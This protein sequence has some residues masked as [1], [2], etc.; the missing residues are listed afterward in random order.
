ME[1]QRC[2]NCKCW[3]SPADF[4]GA[5]GSTVKRCTK[6][7]EKDIRQKQRPEVREKRNELQR[8]KRYD[9]AWRQRKREADKEAYLKH[10]AAV[11]R[12]W[13]QANKSH[14]K[15]WRT[16]NVRQ[17]LGGIMSQAKTKGYAWALEL[18]A[19][20]AMMK[21]PCFYCGIASED[22]LNGIDRMDSSVG[23]LP[24]NC[25]P[26]CGTCN[27]MKKSLD[28]LTFV[29]RCCQISAHHG[30]PGK[31]CTCW[32]SQRGASYVAYRHRAQKKNM[33][34]DLTKQQ[35]DTLC[36]Q[37][38]S[39]CGRSTTGDHRNG[40]DR[41][42]DTLGYTSSNCVPCCGQCN[43]SKREMHGDAYVSK[44]KAIA[45]LACDT[46][47]R[48]PAMPRCLLVIRKRGA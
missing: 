38:C 45:A 30:G 4:I 16:K 10:N 27:F 33:V 22:T 25:V 43:A 14:V 23:Y 15:A 39:Y 29:E 35:F 32:S 44:A 9:V 12:K 21:A 5:R 46:V 24:A 37:D 40:V 26:C 7:R 13:V 20:E 34:F 19:A 11:M 36:A 41:K 3:R 31:P 17:R 28:A 42:D 47:Q 8:Q 1:P 6:C 18:P 48:I 2:T